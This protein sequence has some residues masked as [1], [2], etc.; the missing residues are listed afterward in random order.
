[1]QLEFDSG[2]RE[3][4]VNGKGVLRFH[5]ADPNLYSRFLEAMEQIR[6]MEDTIAVQA[7]GLG[8]DDG[9]QV[10]VLLRQT[11]RRIKELLNWVFGEGNDFDKLLDG[12]NLLAMA[13]NGKRVLENLFAALEPVLEQGAQECADAIAAGNGQ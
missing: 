12:V 2:I 8:N 11:D 10:L 7:Q 13:G 1:M 6:A 5:P 4:T 3:Y 9:S